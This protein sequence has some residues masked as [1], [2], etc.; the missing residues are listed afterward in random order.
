[1]SKENFLHVYAAAHIRAFTPENI[2][3]SFRKTGLVPFNPDIIT[4]E[5]MAPS[6]ESLSAG[7]M[8]LAN[9]QGSL[10]Q[11]ISALL[12][13]HVA[14]KWKATEVEEQDTPVSTTRRRN[15]AAL[16]HS[17]S[18]Q[19]PSDHCCRATETPSPFL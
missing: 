18:P 10:V 17:Q 13:E 11:A 6:L 2:K 7:V 1:M 16:Q 9:Q 15:P 14:R 8:P 3:A 4:A 12:Q 19:T 5:M